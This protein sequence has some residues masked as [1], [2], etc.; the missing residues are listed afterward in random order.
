MI[1][2]LSELYAHIPRCQLDDEGTFKYILI[3]V[4]NTETKEMVEFVRGL[5]FEWENFSIFLGYKRFEYHSEIFKNFKGTVG[6]TGLNIEFGGATHG[7]A[8][9]L[10]L[11]CPGGGRVE[12]S[13][14]F[15][16]GL[17]SK[18]V[19]SKPSLFIYGYSQSYGQA[20]HNHVLG[21]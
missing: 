8:D 2:D 12:Y 5:Y 4:A 14:N 20:D 19:E 6:K 13:S 1:S 9:C 10:H 18:N 16:L 7:L 11:S 21:L 15:N 3:Q 17:P